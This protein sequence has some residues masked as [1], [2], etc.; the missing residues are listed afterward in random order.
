MYLPLLSL[1]YPCSLHPLIA[2]LCGVAMREVQNKLRQRV[3]DLS[4]ENNTLSASNTVL[5]DE[6][7]QYVKCATRCAFLRSS[8]LV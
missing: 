6:V 5:E 3:N 2:F 4:N 7:G 8:G 1:L